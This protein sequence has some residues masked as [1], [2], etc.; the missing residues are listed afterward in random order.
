MCRSGVCGALVRI[1]AFLGD[2]AFAQIL[3]HNKNT[4]IAKEHTSSCLSLY[5]CDAS[6]ASPRLDLEFPCISK[7]T[8][9]RW[10]MSPGV[11]NEWHAHWLL[12]G[13]FL[14]GHGSEPV[15]VGCVQPRVVPG[16]PMNGSM[17]GTAPAAASS[18]RATASAL[19]RHLPLA[20][21]L[22]LNLCTSP[23][24]NKKP[25]DAYICSCGALGQQR[26]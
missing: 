11:V 23:C 19:W 21:L 26:N 2:P 16:A 24:S 14:R 3:K 17:N 8:F 22:V 6:V 5:S 10:V 9:C 15:Y 18:P 12:G 7:A 13:N 1:R 4:L 20:A 25:Q